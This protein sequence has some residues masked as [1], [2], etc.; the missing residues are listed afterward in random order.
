M[1]EKLSKTNVAGIVFSATI[2]YFF[3]HFMGF[4]TLFEKKFSKQ[5]IQIREKINQP[6]GMLFVILWSFFP[7]VPTD[8]MCYVAGTVKMNFGKFILA[9]FIGEL[10]IVAAYVLAGRGIFELL[11]NL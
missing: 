4:D 10:P 3:S 8:V 11:L 9:V 2:I 1:E 7:L 6:K 5:I